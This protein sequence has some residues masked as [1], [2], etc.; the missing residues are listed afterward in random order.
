MD[1]YENNNRPDQLAFT[2][3][4]LVSSFTGK[5]TRLRHAWYSIQ[6]IIYL[7]YITNKYYLAEYYKQ[8]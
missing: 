6:R 4:F 3:K 8:L 7:A 5:C 1:E 2:N